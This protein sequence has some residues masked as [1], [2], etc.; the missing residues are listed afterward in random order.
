MTRNLNEPIRNQPKTGL[1][2]RKEILYQ[3]HRSRKKQR[4]FPIESLFFLL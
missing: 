3:Y 4:Q 2:T 1:R